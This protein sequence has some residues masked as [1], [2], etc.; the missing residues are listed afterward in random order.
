MPDLKACETLRKTAARYL[1]ASINN[2]I[3]LPRYFKKVIKNLNLKKAPIYDLIS[4][5]IL[6]KLAKMG[7][8]FIAQLYNA[9]LR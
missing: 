5:Q 2:N 4:N 6:Q 8:K 1:S 9:V 3:G 7:I